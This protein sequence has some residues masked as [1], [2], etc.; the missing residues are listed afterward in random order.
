MCLC[1]PIIRQILPNLTGKFLF[2]Y[3]M[4]WFFWHLFYYRE[5]YRQVSIDDAHNVFQMLSSGSF[6]FY[7]TEAHKPKAVLGS[8]YIVVNPELV[9]F[10]GKAK[11]AEI[12]S[13]NAIQCQTVLAKCMGP[14]DTW[15]EKLKVS[16]ILKV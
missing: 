1:L 3:I 10:G 8:F 7:F 6:H 11:K 14:I 15:K 4:F 12:M 2:G 16:Y 9:V 13:V 5:T